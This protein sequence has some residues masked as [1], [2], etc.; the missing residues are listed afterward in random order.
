MTKRQSA[1]AAQYLPSASAW[2]R[3]PLC[4]PP[5]REGKIAQSHK[6]PKRRQGFEDLEVFNFEIV[7]IVATGAL[8]NGRLCK[9]RK[10]K[11]LK[12]SFGGPPTRMK[13][14]LN[15]PSLSLPLPGSTTFGLR[16][17]AKNKQCLKNTSRCF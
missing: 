9:S 16:Q 2:R 1:S 3:I 17:P 10:P 14:C 6:A 7:L 5:L 13:F 11:K 15:S 8:M 4:R 12:N